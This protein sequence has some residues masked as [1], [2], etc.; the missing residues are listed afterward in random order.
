MLMLRFSVLLLALFGVAVQAGAEEL[1][2]TADESGVDEAVGEQTQRIYRTVDDQGRPVFTDAPGSGRPA[3]EVQIREQNTIPMVV[4]RAAA[5]AEEKTKAPVRYELA[6]TSPKSE[7]TLHNPES[8]TVAV[9]VTPEPSKGHVLRL[10]NNGEEVAMVIEWPERGEH[11]LVAQ[12]LGQEGE[13]LAESAEVVVY[14]QRVSILN[15]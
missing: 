6:I 13:V 2:S 3:Q 7:E 12:V 1:S 14:V 8:M 10:L 11:R 5:P 15:K 4:P 9:S